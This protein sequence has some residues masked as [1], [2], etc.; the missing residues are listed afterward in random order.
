MVLKFPKYRQSRIDEFLIDSHTNREEKGLTERASGNSLGVKNSMSLET[1]YLQSS[2][3][4][5]IRV[6]STIELNS[7]IKEAEIMYKDSSYL[8]E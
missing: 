4:A 7:T 2:S 1:V 8:I 5:F 6:D 3:E